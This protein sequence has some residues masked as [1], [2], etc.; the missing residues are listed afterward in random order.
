MLFDDDDDDESDFG[1]DDETEKYEDSDETQSENIASKE[2]S[3]L[4]NKKKVKNKK[5]KIIEID[6]KHMFSDSDQDILDD[7]SNK[8]TNL[9]S[10]DTEEFEEVE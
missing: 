9:T 2:D 7:E 4:A 10:S 6:S 3:K 5:L 1:K 8:Q